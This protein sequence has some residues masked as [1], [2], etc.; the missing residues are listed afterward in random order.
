M[1]GFE[2]GGSGNE[3][4]KYLAGSKG[5]QPK[6]KKKDKPTLTPAQ[7]RKLQE[8]INGKQK[9]PKVTTKYGVNTPQ[10]P[11]QLPPG[12][13]TKYGI[14]TPQLPP[15]LPPGSHTKYG[16]NTPQFPQLPPNGETQTRYGIN[17]P[18]K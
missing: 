12:S 17:F 16:V 14:N 18:K 1:A 5:P 7:K 10:L 15:Q 13:H 4:D 2:I 11:P 8:L 3:Y 9:P 6:P